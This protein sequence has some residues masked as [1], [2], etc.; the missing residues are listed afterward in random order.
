[1]LLLT[2]IPKLNFNML[3]FSTERLIKFIRWYLNKLIEL[4]SYFSYFVAAACLF[5]ALVGIFHF[6]IMT[7]PHVSF[8]VVDKA[9]LALMID[10]DFTPSLNYNVKQ[11][12]FSIYAVKKTT[13][14]NEIRQT[15]FDK[16]LVR[17]NSFA[18]KGKLKPTLD[19][20]KSFYG[21]DDLQWFIKYEVVPY[22]GILQYREYEV[23][24]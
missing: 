6:R 3:E 16:L 24:I 4:T 14:E 10:Y 13:K 1:M 2:V 19:I 5:Y 20:P 9:S 23:T 11:I 8:K 18:F 17:G 12:Y 15:I 22:L 7:S 21:A